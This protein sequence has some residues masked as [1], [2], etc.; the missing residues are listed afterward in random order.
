MDNKYYTPSIEEFHIGFEY[1]VEAEG[2]WEDSV[3]DVWGWYRYKFYTGTCFR[4]L[5]DIKEKLK[6]NLIRV[7]YLDREDIESLGFE[8]KPDR[9]MS[10][11]YGGLFTIPSK[12]YHNTNIELRKWHYNNRINIDHCGTIFDGLIKNK[13]ELKKLLEQLRII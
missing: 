9:N 1:E 6:N 4:D 5:D 11:G 13:N 7:K 8:F 3:E 10:E 12:T 2:S